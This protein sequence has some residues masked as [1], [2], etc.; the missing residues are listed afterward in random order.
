[1]SLKKLATILG[2]SETTIR[3]ITE[4]DLRHLSTG[5]RIGSHVQNWL[6]DNV[7]MFWFKEFWPSNSPDLNFLDY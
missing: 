6:S 3:R 4:E 2:V 5:Q 1:M 7:D